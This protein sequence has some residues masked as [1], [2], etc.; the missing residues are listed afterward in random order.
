MSHIDKLRIMV[1]NEEPHIIG[2]KKTKIDPSI[3]DSQITVDGYDV[4]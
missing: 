3:N 1:S 4:I 2:I